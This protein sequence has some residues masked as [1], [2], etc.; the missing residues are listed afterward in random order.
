MT[1]EK[2]DSRREVMNV[3]KLWTAEE[4]EALRK[5]EAKLIKKGVPEHKAYMQAE[6][7]LEQRQN[8]AREQKELGTPN[9]PKK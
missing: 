1:G 8:R 3:K 2:D 7:E 9:P 5:I 6:N 4:Q